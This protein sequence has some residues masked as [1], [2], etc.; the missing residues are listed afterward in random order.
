MWLMMQQPEPDDYV[1]ATGEAHSV[2]EFIEEA[3]ALLDRRLEWRGEGVNEVGI[4]TKT[5]KVLVE[6]D[7]RYFRPTEVDTLLGDA[8]KARQR[9]GWK[10][11]VTFKQLVAEMVQSDLKAVDAGA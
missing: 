4:D 10:P 1:L 3:F 7:P 9:L 5:G 2:R 6:V 11:V 8:S